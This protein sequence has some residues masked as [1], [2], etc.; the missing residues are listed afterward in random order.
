MGKG[1][2][3]KRVNLW[4]LLTTI[5][6]ARVT[7]IR[8]PQGRALRALSLPWTRLA[9]LGAANAW[10]RPSLSPHG[11]REGTRKDAI[12]FFV[13][14]FAASNVFFDE[15]ALRAVSAKFCSLGLFKGKA[16]V[17]SVAMNESTIATL[18]VIFSIACWAWIIWLMKRSGW[19]PPVW[20]A[21][22]VA[23]GRLIVYAKW[24]YGGTCV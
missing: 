3:S 17:L 10:Q 6:N 1:D 16:S 7:P 2:C 23:V 11:L 14:G 19:R 15:F 22:V 5:P 21:A 4:A 13:F 20:V 24:I 12:A 18:G 9:G 8:P